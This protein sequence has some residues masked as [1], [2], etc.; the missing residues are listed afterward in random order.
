[1]AKLKF[2]GADE[3]AGTSAAG[4]AHFD[5]ATVVYCLNTNAAAQLVTVCNASNT[6]QGSFHLGAGASQQVIKK[7]TDKVFAASA[8]VKLTPVAH[9]A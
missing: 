6:T 8:D 9:H 2:L 4:C 3:N 1:M 5:G 7:P